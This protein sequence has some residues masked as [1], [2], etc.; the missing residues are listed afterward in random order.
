M[1][2]CARTPVV[3]RKSR[4]DEEGGGG[5]QEEEGGEELHAAGRLFCRSKRYERE[6]SS[7]QIL[8]VIP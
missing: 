5:G 8:I 7:L 6:A 4:G 3:L 1:L 2:W